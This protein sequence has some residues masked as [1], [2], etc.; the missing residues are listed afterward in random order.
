[1]ESERASEPYCMCVAQLAI[2]VLILVQDEHRMARFAQYAMVASEEALNDS[3]WFP[4]REEDLE[5]TVW[6]LGTLFVRAL[7]TM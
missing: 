4:K 7:L 5:L 6:R 3:G 2:S 1:M